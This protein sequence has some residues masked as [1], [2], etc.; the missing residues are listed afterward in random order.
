MTVFERRLLDLS[1]VINSN[2]ETLI[3][4]DNFANA[5]HT[6]TRT[7]WGKNGNEMVYNP[8]EGRF[9]DDEGDSLMEWANHMIV[10]DRRRMPEFPI[11]PLNLDEYNGCI[12]RHLKGIHFYQFKRMRRL[13]GLGTGHMALN[14]KN[15]NKVVS[16]MRQKQIDVWISYVYRAFA[17]LDLPDFILYMI[18]NLTID[19]PLYINN[20]RSR[21]MIMKTIAKIKMFRLSL[22]N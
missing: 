20:P 4:K 10:P 22:T 9:S 1:H 18:I 13:I 17:S 5:F 8:R 12:G 15:F 19:D 6:E 14:H 11:I 2:N 7:Y 21:D 16:L 3:I